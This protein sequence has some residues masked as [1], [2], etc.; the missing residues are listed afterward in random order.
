MDCLQ[1][2]N[3]KQSIS[4]FHLQ[5]TMII[6]R[7]K[8]TTMKQNKDCN[9]D[10]TKIDLRDTRRTHVRRILTLSSSCVAKVYF[11]VVFIAIFV[12][13]HGC[14]ELQLGRP[15]VLIIGPLNKRTG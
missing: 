3:N 8:D 12:L 7:R 4:P 13:F 2:P 1:A 6:A 10:N 5:C 15:T 14:F 11:C 9:E